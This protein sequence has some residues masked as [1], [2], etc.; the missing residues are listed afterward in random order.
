MTRPV[1]KFFGVIALV[2]FVLIYVL[3]A[4]AIGSGRILEAPTLVKFGY[5]LVAGILWVLPAGLL[6]RW[7]QKPDPNA[8]Q[9]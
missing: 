1:R 8:P 4:A 3:I 6:I 2:S 9:E 5:F 7:M